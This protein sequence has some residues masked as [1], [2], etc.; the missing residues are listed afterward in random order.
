MN[1][2]ITDSIQTKE[3]QFPNPLST[4]AMEGQELPTTGKEPICWTYHFG[5]ID[6]KRLHSE[7][8]WG[9]PSQYSKGLEVSD[10]PS[11]NLQQEQPNGFLGEVDASGSSQVAASTPASSNGSITV[12]L[13]WA[14]LFLVFFVLKLTGT[15][16]WPWIYVFAPV[17]LQGV[18]VVAAFLSFGILYEIRNRMWSS[19]QGD[20]SYSPL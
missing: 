8:D 16:E 7:Q 6:P 4:D 9:L 3:N 2:V 13:T 10:V 15:I 11:G 18:I 1:E 17:I 20:A 12:S 14:V 19:A 5:I